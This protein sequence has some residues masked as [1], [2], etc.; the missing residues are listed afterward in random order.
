[1]QAKTAR[2]TIKS[3][4]IYSYLNFSS[5]CLSLNVA[6]YCSVGRLLLQ[7]AYSNKN[8]RYLEKQ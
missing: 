7:Y 5:E 8:T 1:M 6:K 4:I 2:H 3:N